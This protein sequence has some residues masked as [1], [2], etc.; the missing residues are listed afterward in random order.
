M[1]S[2][3]LVLNSVDRVVHTRSTRNAANTQARGSRLNAFE[4]VEINCALLRNTTIVAL[5]HIPFSLKRTI[6]SSNS[7]AIDVGAVE[8]R[9]AVNVTHFS[10]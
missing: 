3:V 2:F 6:S 1:P 7:G 9:D 5:R 8:V 4:S 10:T